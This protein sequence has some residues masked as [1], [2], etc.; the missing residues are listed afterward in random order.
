MLLII[1]GGLTSPIGTVIAGVIL[2]VTEIYSQAYLAPELGSFGHNIHEV[3]PYV[4]MILF[5]MVRPYGLFG[6]EQVERV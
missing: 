5:L 3:F 1:V 4:V 6:E 2:G